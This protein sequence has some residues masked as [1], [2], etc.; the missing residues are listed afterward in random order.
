MIRRSIISGFS[1]R[2]KRLNL[3]CYSTQSNSFKSIT[4]EDLPS[5]A[6]LFSSPNTSVSGV[7]YPGAF[8]LPCYGVLVC[9][10][11]EQGGSP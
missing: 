1:N 6:S 10:G 5:L 9:Y 2:F 3:S 4:A 7:S 8:P 11:C